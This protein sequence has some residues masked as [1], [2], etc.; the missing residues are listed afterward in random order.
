M[1][2]INNLL[3][4]GAGGFIGS[5]L[6]E[7]F[8]ELGYKVRA[9]VHYNSKNSSGWLEPTARRK[10]LKIIAGD[11]CDYE[12]VYQ[13]MRGVDTV[14]HLA[15]L[16]GIPYS[17]SAPISYMRTNIE[18][19]HN[20]ILAAKNLKVKNVLIAST[21]E[22]YGSAQYVPIDEKHPLVGQSPYAASKIAADQLALS[23]Y[24]S[25]GLP[26]KIVRP[27]N[28]YGPRQSARAII[29]TIILQVLHKKR[30]L[31]LGN[32]APMRDFTYVKDIVEGFVEIA[33]SE[34]FFGEVTN[35][36]TGEEISIRDLAQ[37]IVEMMDVDVKI[38]IDEKRIRP[39]KSEVERL[40]CD[41][42]KLKKNTNWR[43]KYHLE[44]GLVETIKWFSINPHLYKSEIYNI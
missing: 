25:Y 31:K 39:Q 37:K 24:H 13:A 44:K 2:K 27:F 7:R 20:V 1:I 6:T 23:F 18:G 14:V 11:V 42:S 41:C 15:A 8:I 26:I 10:D 3:L 30:L 4:T 32:L 9:F 29:P 34:K 38:S 22:T 28:T 40:L 21:S 43:P 16:V 33:L 17:Y 36:G 19:T 12:L 5:H 35:V